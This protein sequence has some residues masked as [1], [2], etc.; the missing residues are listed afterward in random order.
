MQHS[1]DR[2]NTLTRD[3]VYV[4]LG[5]HHQQIRP[6]VTAAEILINNQWQQ[7]IASS[8][9]TALTHIETQ[10]N[11]IFILLADQPSVRAETLQGML[12][13][14]DGNHVVCAYY[15]GQ[16]GVP[17]IFPSVCFSALRR[18]TGDQGAKKLLQEVSLPVLE[19]T[20]PEAA[21][22][23]D[24]QEQLVALNAPHN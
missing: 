16:R 24:T 1:I 17:A 4:V 9:V 8:I 3:P 21:L 5:A 20:L 12:N 2:A 11:A 19:W 23:V 15:G 10:H 18:L 7:G 22:D 14:F 13:A 6:R